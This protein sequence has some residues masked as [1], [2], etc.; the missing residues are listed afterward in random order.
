MS[1]NRAALGR[2][3]ADRFSLLQSVVTLALAVGGA[4]LTAGMFQ[5]G[6][7]ARLSALETGAQ[8]QEQAIEKN[9]TER[10]SRLGEKLD[11]KVYEADKQI[12]LDVKKTVEEIRRTQVEDLKERASARPRR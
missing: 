9:R 8:K 5:G 1:A 2:T 7:T 6:L 10:E 11:V 3:L 12:W 4:L